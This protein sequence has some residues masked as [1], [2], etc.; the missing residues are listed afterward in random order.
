MKKTEILLIGAGPIGIEM[1]AALKERGV[2]YIHVE[3]GCIGS[4]IAWYAP[5]TVYFSTPERLSLANIPFETYPHLKATREEY[6]HYLR[7]VVQ[8]FSLKIST[9]T[10]VVSV[11]KIEN[12]F[13][14]TIRRSLSGVGGQAEIEYQKSKKPETFQDEIIFSKKVIFSIGDMHFPNEI[15]IPGEDGPFVSHFFSDPH[16]RVGQRVI[17]LG[18][19]NSSAEACVRLYRAGAKVS[20]TYRGAELD[21]AKVKP[22]V[23]PELKN[24]IKEGKIKFYPESK[25]VRIEDS[26]L[27]IRG[28]DGKEVTI[29]G[30][31]IYLLTGYRQDPALYEQLGI[32][33]KGDRRRPEYNPETQETN[34][35]NAFVI[36][37]GV[38]GS[39]SGNTK[40][41]I[42]T[43]HVH[44]ER[45]M[46][47]F[48]FSDFCLNQTYLREEEDREM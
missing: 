37:T 6:L 1:A 22:W 17:V 30:D 5:G 40:H 28:K 12:G 16:L 15:N 11:S 47:Y 29:A 26:D 8:K 7:Q 34:I 25:P 35:S 44:V 39:Q 13:T 20:L 33:L 2:D 9:Y 42:E 46:H 18:G 36:G 31:Y 41:F 45:I 3:A 27:V 48:G 4:T 19:K 43:S 14:S 10:R 23:L 21:S 24:L 38:A 32:N